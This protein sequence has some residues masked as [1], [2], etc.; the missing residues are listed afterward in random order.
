MLSAERKFAML[1][2]QTQADQ[3]RAS[4]GAVIVPLFDGDAILGLID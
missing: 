1:W 2:T 4:D 3:G